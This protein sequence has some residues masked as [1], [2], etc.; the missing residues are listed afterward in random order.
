MAT[1]TVKIAELLTAKEAAVYLGVRLR[2]R[3]YA[4][5]TFYNMCS[6]GDMA[7]PDEIR[8]GRPRWSPARLD[9]WVS[10]QIRRPN[11]RRRRQSQTGKAK[12]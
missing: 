12:Q 1:E 3:P 6:T 8:R 5:R 2:G 11:C 4:L 7:P 9:E 10:K